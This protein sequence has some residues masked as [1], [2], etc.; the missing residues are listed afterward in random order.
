M[1]AASADL[2]ALA[3]DLR[4]AGD[5]A[6]KM[7]HQLLAE[8]AGTVQSLAAAK[9]PR[10]KGTLSNS[11]SVRWE[12][13]LTAVIGP[14]VPYGVFQEFGTG[15]RGEFPGDAYEI[16]PR[17]ASVLRF[18][19]GGRTVYAKVVHHPGVAPHPFMRPAAQ[20]ALGPLAEKLAE[21]GA[22][23]ITKGPKA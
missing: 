23:S 4:Q 5:D 3:S 17:K 20:E 11:I 22:L 15:E 16:R 1:S 7:A 21:Q 14:T 13:D 9:A 18:T 6:T 8:T 19:V 2:T 12:G 10:K